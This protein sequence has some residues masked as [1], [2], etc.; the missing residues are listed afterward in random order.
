MIVL[1]ICYSDLEGGAAKAAFRLHKAQRSLGIDSK[2]LVADKKSDDPNVIEVSRLDHFRMRVF[3]FISRQILRLQ[4]D[5]NRV[6]HS[7]NLFPSGLLKYIKRIS[8]DIVNLHWLGGEMISIGEIAKITLPLVWTLHDMWAFCG[9]E[10]YEDTSAPSRYRDGYTNANRPNLARGFDLDQWTYRRKRKAWKG[11][12][13]Q[14]VAPS[15]WIADCVNR[16]ALLKNNKVTIINNCVN[17]TVFKPLST[18]HSREALNL[19]HD[20]KLLLFGAMSSTSD[21]RK[22]YSYLKTALKLLKARGCTDNLA[23]VVF[24]AGDGDAQSETGITTY[25]L[26][27]MSDDVALSLAYNAA[28]IFVA[29]SLQD[30]LPN[31]LVEALC[32]GTPCVAFGVGGIPEIITNEIEGIVVEAANAEQL[33]V[34]LEKQLAKLDSLAG[35]HL[36]LAK[37]RFDIEVA[38]QYHKLYKQLLESEE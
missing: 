28:D 22:G 1:H 25:Y 20:K 33:S 5:G 36:T 12:Q 37:G 24:G 4:K 13:I 6:F 21:P 38:D 8:P 30:N 9:A 16:S 35:Q 23:L 34:A 17:R 11:L 26:G 15:G 32:C 18:I 10:H 31:T 3:A 2:M 27:R 29:P 7:L 19:P 14:I